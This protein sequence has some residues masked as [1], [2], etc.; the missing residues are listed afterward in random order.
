MSEAK[1]KKT[2]VEI[3][4]LDL[5]DANKCHQI[6]VFD[7]DPE[8][9]VVPWIAQGPETVTI[10]FSPLEGASEFWK[11]PEMFCFKTLATLPDIIERQ[12][13]L[14]KLRKQ[15]PE[16]SVVLVTLII[17]TSMW[18]K[19]KED[20]PEKVVEKKLHTDL[21]ENLWENARHLNLR[22]IV[23]FQKPLILS[24]SFRCQC[25]ALLFRGDYLA[26]ILTTDTVS[27]PMMMRFLS[28]FNLPDHLGVTIDDTFRAL[29]ECDVGDNNVWCRM[30]D[31]VVFWRPNHSTVETQLPYPEAY[32]SLMKVYKKD[33]PK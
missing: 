3:A 10:V 12:E 2:Q 26:R 1:E 11:V 9:L 16:T 27:K 17:D 4:E 30:Y 22:V 28:A 14:I 6:L 23:T 32:H 8:T 7:S 33:A 20:N 21:F 18:V 24:P 15:K 13:Q 31:H 5:K 25:E 29:I 19:G